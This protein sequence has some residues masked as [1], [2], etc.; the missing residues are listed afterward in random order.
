MILPK[1]S[2]ELQMKS[3]LYFSRT[4]INSI[5]PTHARA[6]AWW[7]T[8]EARPMRGGGPQ[9]GARARWHICK[10]TLD[11][12]AIQLEVRNT[13]PIDCSYTNKPFPLLSF[14]TVRSSGHPRARR[15]SDDG[16]GWPRR[17]AGTRAGST[18]GPTPVYNP[19]VYTSLG[20]RSGSA[21]GSGDHGV[22]PCAIAARPCRP[23]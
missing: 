17:P 11:L 7:P 22:R 5:Q 10:N 21:R 4:R 3:Y 19:S 6:N 8:G 1:F 20:Y 14:T 2:S 9:Q 18:N 16:I 23:P 12:P 15:G 13:I